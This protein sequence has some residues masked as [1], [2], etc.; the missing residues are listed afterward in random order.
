MIP[1]SARALLSVP[2]LITYGTGIAT[3]SSA[4]SALHIAST[5]SPSNGTSRALSLVIVSTVTF[6]PIKLLIVEF[7]S[8]SKPG[9]KRP[10]IVALA[11][12]GIT[13]AL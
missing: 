13:F 6:S 7:N 2:P 5:K 3:E 11:E 1:K 10:S 12:P 9:I 4:I 8:S